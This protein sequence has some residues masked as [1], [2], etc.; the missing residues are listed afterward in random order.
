MS[1]STPESVPALSDRPRIHRERDSGGWSAP[2]R[3]DV[4]RS[5]ARR[6]IARRR[7]EIGDAAQAEE[8]TELLVLVAASVV[9]LQASSD[10]PLD[11]RMRSTLGRRLLELLR[12]EVVRSWAGGDVDR[13][14]MPGI[15]AA[16]ERVREAIEPDWAHDFAARLSGPDGLQILVDVAHDLRS[17]LT[18]ILFL[19]ETL[20]RGQSG[21]VTDVQR[22][23]LGLIYSA[24][25]GLSSVASDVIELA[26]GGAELVEQEPVPFSIGTTLESVRD[27]VR[28]MAEE[29]QLTVRLL[30]PR[31]DE[32]VGHPV[33]LSRVLLNLTT[34]ALKFTDQGYVE[35]VTQEEGTSR[36]QFAVRDSGRG[37]DP[38]TLS[39]LY[40]PLRQA[41]GG[42]AHVFSQTGLGL[43]MCRRLLE[44]MGS[45]LKVESHA[46]WG[47]R[48]YFDLD[49]PHCPRPR[50]RGT[51]GPLRSLV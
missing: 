47:T 3:S 40:R 21:P 41:A 51:D 36:V 48:F 38:A 44:A 43:T 9:E 2:I 30:P 1:R 23:Q 28:P 12:A 29:K 18:S 17:P 13:D 37:I 26:R 35:I 10:A 11:E 49:L 50:H 8:V 4:L 31:T 27:I 25:L 5:A 22:R 19:A 46:G 24:A 14:E 42:G 45:E 15:L 33:A 32:R 16:M 34:N 7:D 39:T 6:V 20:Q